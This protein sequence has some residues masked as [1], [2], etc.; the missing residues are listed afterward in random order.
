[1]KG[2]SLYICLIV[3]FASCSKKT[4]IMSNPETQDNLISI[5]VKEKIYSKILDQER[6]VWIYKPTSYYGMN[7][8]G[9][10]YPVV[11]VMDGESQ[12]LATASIVDM[13]SSPGSA[14]DVIP[15]MIV[16]GIVNIDRNIDLTPKMTSTIDSLALQSS[17]GA[18]KMALFMR[19]ELIPF[20]DRKY[21]TSDHRVL[22]G[23]S[24]GG[25]YVLNTLIHHPDLFTN[26]LSIDPFMVWD[27]EKFSE[28]VLDSLTN[29]D[30]QDKNLYI[31]MANNTLS[32]MDRDEAMQDTSEVMKMMNANTRF[33]NR[34]V[35]EPKSLDYR[36][37]YYEDENHFQIPLPAMYDGFNYF[38]D[39][40]TFAEMADYYHPS[41]ADMSILPAFKEHFRQASDKLGYDVKPMES[42]VN[43]WAW[44]FVQLGS[45]DNA[46]A[47]L[48]LNIEY[49][50][51]SAHVYTSMGHFMLNQND[52][53]AAKQY[54]KQS[55]S[56]KEDAGVRE[57]LKDF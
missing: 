6:E 19:D 55:L 48:Q 47:L 46:K 51:K 23:H 31:A 35:K 49:Y 45:L 36:M 2:L 53:T 52:V 44:G 54:L 34:M 8:Q 41:K 37:L 22:I 32:Y 38:Y 56:I 11:Y 13:L 40:Y 39:Y 25:L 21:N 57:E 42:Y 5:G 3:F 18:D 4:M 20:V 16:V 1:M 15:Q 24:L 50:P 9:T 12:F 28:V 30:Y 33:M 14:N 10:N 26:Y 29:S 43:S 7:E 27:E 17:G